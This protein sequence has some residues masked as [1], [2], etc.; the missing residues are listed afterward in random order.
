MQGRSQKRWFNQLPVTKTWPSAWIASCSSSVARS[1]SSSDAPGGTAPEAQRREFRWRTRLET[2]HRGDPFVQ[3]LRQ[4]HLL[5]ER[6][7]E[8]CGAVQEERKE[9]P[10]PAEVLRQFDRLLRRRSGSASSDS[11]RYG[12][13][14][15]RASR[16]AA[17]RTTTAPAP[18]GTKSDLWGSSTTESDC[19][20]PRKRGAKRVHQ[21]VEA[22]VRGVDVVPQA[23]RA[24]DGA[25]GVERIDRSA[26]HGARG[27]QHE[28][29]R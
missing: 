15:R 9:H 21:H 2:V 12:A 13:R 20:I 24:C 1:A 3:V 11:T 28:P 18:Y 7:G 27:R 23:L 14:K 29:G 8:R 5:F 22:A 19:S 16:C 17:S 10:Q 25:D 4:H 6:G 26:V